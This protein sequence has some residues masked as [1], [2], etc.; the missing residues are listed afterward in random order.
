MNF[1]VVWVIRDLAK[2]AIAQHRRSVALFL[3]I[4]FYFGL[5]YL[6]TAAIASQIAGQTLHTQ[7]EAYYTGKKNNN[8][9]M[10]REAE[11]SFV[12]IWNFLYRGIFGGYSL[13]CSSLWYFSFLFSSFVICSFNSFI[14]FES[15]RFCF[16]FFVFSACQ[17]LI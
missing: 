4:A 6:I 17:M 15:F 14:S 2:R 1:L 9:E 8:S 13:F 11:A 3:D 12:I 7:L 10:Q 5:A 16:L